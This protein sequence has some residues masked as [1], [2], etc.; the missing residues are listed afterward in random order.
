[1]RAAVERKPCPSRPSALE[2]RADRHSD[3]TL[4]VPGV[5]WADQ[6]DL[7]WH[8]A[9]RQRSSDH[10]EV[11]HRF[12][13]AQGD[14]QLFLLLL[15]SRLDGVELLVECEARLLQVLDLLLVGALGVVQLCLRGRDGTLSACASLLLSEFFAVR[16]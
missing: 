13:L 3:G 9:A 7:P 12:R 6:G 1:M 15:P 8:S 11:I 10:L 2:C 14:F 4:P 16:L 5:R